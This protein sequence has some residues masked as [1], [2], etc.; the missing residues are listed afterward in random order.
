[1][2][3]GYKTDVLTDTKYA[4][5]MADQEKSHKERDARMKYGK[6]YKKFMNQAKDAKDRLRPGE[7]K[8]WDPDKKKYVSNKD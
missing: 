8:K 5:R 6:N 2:L 7:V 3:E 4:K 1:M